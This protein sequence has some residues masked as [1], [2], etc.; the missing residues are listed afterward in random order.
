MDTHNQAQRQPLPIWNYPLQA[1]THFPFNHHLPEVNPR[2]KDPSLLNITLGHSR[3]PMQQQR[4]STAKSGNCREEKGKTG[5]RIHCTISN[6]TLKRLVHATRKP[7]SEALPH[8]ENR[9]YCG[10][11]CLGKQPRLTNDFGRIAARRCDVLT[12]TTSRVEPLRRPSAGRDAGG[13]EIEKIAAVVWIDM[14]M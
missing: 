11:H 8:Q 1:G 7:L 10:Q 3:P 6:L 14:A 12:A 4:K 2:L 13:F 9:P 5:S